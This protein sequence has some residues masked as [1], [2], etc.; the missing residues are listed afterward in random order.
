[1]FAQ[2][3]YSIISGN[4]GSA[5]SL[6]SETGELSVSSVSNSPD[7]EVTPSYN[8]SIQAADL[9]PSP[10]A[11][12]LVN[13][14]ISVLDVNDNSPVFSETIYYVDLEESSPSGKS[15]ITVLATDKD[16]DTN[17]QIEYSIVSGNTDGMFSVDED[18]GLISTTALPTDRESGETHQ[19][20]IQA[21]D[22]GPTPR[23]GT[24]GLVITLL[25]IND[26][27]PTFEDSIYILSVLENVT[28][29]SHIGV[30]TAV[31][32]DST[33]NGTV[34]YSV[35]PGAAVPFD[36]I[37]GTSILFTTGT[38]DREDTPLY[39]FMLRASDLGT[40]ARHTD[41]VI[42]II[43]RDV[44]DNSPQ[45]LNSD[46]SVNVFEN[47]SLGAQ[48]FLVD[49]IDADIDLNRKIVFFLSGDEGMFG[50]GRD[51]GSVFTISELDRE[52]TDSYQLIITARDGGDPSLTSDYTLLVNVMDI[53]DNPPT[54][55]TSYELFVSE[56]H[57]LSSP[58]AT[59]SAPD[60]DLAMNA[61]VTYSL[62]NA[63]TTV[64]F[65]LSSTGVLTLSHLL[66]YEDTRSYLFTAVATD[67]GQ[68]SL[69]TTVSV[70]ITVED[71][72]D[73]TP[74]FGE[75]FY[76][77]GV[78]E[79]SPHGT[80]VLVLTATDRDSGLYGTVGFEI[81]EP[82]STQEHFSIDSITGQ[83][84]TR[85]LFV[86][87]VGTMYVT[88]VTVS[89]NERSSP[90]NSLTTN[91]TITVITDSY[92]V[93]TVIQC[94]PVEVVSILDQLI[95]SYE[96]VTHSMITVYDVTPHVY[97]NVIDLTKTDMHIFAV[98]S[99]GLV[100]QSDLVKLL[101]EN[102]EL[103]RSVTTCDIQSVSEKTPETVLPNYEPL[104]WSLI[105][106]LSVI[107][108]LGMTCCCLLF[109]QARRYR[110][111]QY[112]GSKDSRFESVMNSLADLS[113]L[114][115]RYFSSSAAINNPLYY[116]PY[117][118]WSSAQSGQTLHY[119]SQELVMEMFRGSESMD[120]VS[121]S[122]LL[123]HGSEFS[124]ELVSP[125][126][127]YDSQDLEIDFRELYRNN[128]AGSEYTEGDER[129]MATQDDLE[130]VDSEEGSI[131]VI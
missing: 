13:V 19:L 63:S 32:P 85:D 23:V 40:P 11:S 35:A 8:L 76:R 44:N 62:Y 83:V 17:Q 53:N 47:V 121:R 92:L 56:S 60:R 107:V 1:M 68:P 16:K 102:I 30:V 25:D 80:S 20:T 70:N 100:P 82:T 41:V 59:L 118:D 94:G 125:F 88:D 22:K 21:Q 46:L 106:V 95:A 96:T 69:S 57:P 48:V 122:L 81:N 120:T 28:L 5:F 89:D 123:P 77:A 127:L 4:V 98:R 130:F 84:T 87:R 45:F 86:N 116:P 42:S 131:S 114:S 109:C 101:D 75:A 97:G 74:V 55:P 78:L 50:I 58:V 124:S 10:R 113:N 129:E 7:R 49:I 66:D 90:S 24:A 65:S 43:V 99:G 33:E 18:T 39:S 72:N 71:A 31:D 9:A 54:F 15:V 73:N 104:Y 111:N 117:D 67:S 79:T 27:S 52:E 36:F 93:I 115:S 110:Q 26:N 38:L 12:E 103:L 34:S 126:D 29:S 14:I 61:A 2:V 6:H 91:L 105:G 3:R 112:T 37:A 119:E 64:P 108:C 128:Q 51:S